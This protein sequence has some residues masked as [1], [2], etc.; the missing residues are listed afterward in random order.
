MASVVCF[1]VFLVGSRPD[2]NNR[3]VCVASK[4]IWVHPDQIRPVVV[5]SVRVTRS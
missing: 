1:V 5:V 3:F 2:A 4:Q